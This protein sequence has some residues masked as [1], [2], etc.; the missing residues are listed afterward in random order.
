MTLTVVW[1]LWV[2]LYIPVVT[3]RMNMLNL[4]LF[5]TYTIYLA[6]CKQMLEW[7]TVNSQPNQDL[8]ETCPF[9]APFFRLAHLPTYKYTW[10]KVRDEPIMI[11]GEAKAKSRKNE[12]ARVSHL[13]RGVQNSPHS[14]DLNPVTL[15]YVHFCK[16][17]M[18]TER[19][20]KWMCA[21]AQAFSFLL[22]DWSRREPHE[23]WYG[24]LKQV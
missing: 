10:W 12:N 7:F 24:A 22:W 11:W 8:K 5:K 18:K 4:S 23:V 13:P 3:N 15:T 17:K 9:C 16:P 2:I 21:N 1:F 14:F 19:L 20:G 6:I